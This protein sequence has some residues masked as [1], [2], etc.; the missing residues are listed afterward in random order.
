MTIKTPYFQ[1]SPHTREGSHESQTRSQVVGLKN[2]FGQP[3]LKAASRSLPSTSSA[4][5]SFFDSNPINSAHSSFDYQV[6][7][8][9]Q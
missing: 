2:P 8:F 5:L 3:W 1:A 9:S 7:V 6:C 4:T